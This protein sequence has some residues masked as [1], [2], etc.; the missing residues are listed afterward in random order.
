[1]CPVLC[2]SWVGHREAVFLLLLLS[3]EKDTL[4]ILF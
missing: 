2:R 3:G 1:M 4:F